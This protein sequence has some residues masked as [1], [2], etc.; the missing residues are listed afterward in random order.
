MGV[1]R[2][3]HSDKPYGNGRTRGRG[4]T[5]VELMVVLAITSLTAAFVLPSLTAFVRHAQFRRNEEQ[6]KSIYLDAEASLTYLRTSGQ[7]ESFR[8]ELV[9]DGA[10]RKQI[11]AETRARE[12]RTVYVLCTGGENGDLE[13]LDRL[14]GADSY[15][16][17]LR[18]AGICVEIDAEAGRV[19][20]AFYSTTADGFTY[21]DEQAE[22]YLGFDARSPEDR[23]ARRLGYYSVEDPVNGAGLPP[24]ANPHLTSL[25]LVNDERLYLTWESDSRE[26]DRDAAFDIELY[27]GEDDSLLWK[28]SLSLNGYAGGCMELA[29]QNGENVPLGTYSFPF[30]YNGRFELVLDAMMDAASLDA[31]APGDGGAR[32]EAVR[33]GSTSVT[34]LPGMDRPLNVYARVTVRSASDRESRF[35]T[36][37][38]NRENTM[39][40]SAPSE[41]G[42]YLIRSFRHL[43]NIRYMEP[44]EAEKPQCFRLDSALDWEL[45]GVEL[46]H[47][48]G[49]R[50]L[51]MSGDLVFPT[52]AEL[53]E[54]QILEG[55]GNTIR[56]LRLGVD[57]VSKR[58][59]LGLIGEN[60]GT[61]RNLRLAGPRIL[62]GGGHILVSTTITCAGTVCGMSGASGALQNI[63]VDGAQIRVVLDGAHDGGE[64]M[65]VGGVAG[66]VGAAAPG[67]TNRE[68]CEAKGL[69]VTGGSVEAYVPNV[70]DAADERSGRRGIGG[71]IGCARTDFY[72]GE[73]GP[74]GFLRVED[75]VNEAN[76]TGNANTGGVVGSLY[77]RPAALAAPP[78][79][80]GQAMR[81]CTNRGEVRG[82]D[83]RAYANEF[84]RAIGAVAGFVYNAGLEDCNNIPRADAPSEG[85]A[86][87]LVGEYAGPPA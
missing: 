84:P 11:P 28:T 33:T 13:L 45:D 9:K 71:V 21:T 53:R 58:S 39:F 16:G 68:S 60:E 22:G 54:G 73:E 19:Y 2:L 31:L 57:S 38:S 50:L 35:H 82:E 76:V 26:E 70:P 47:W 80:P 12:A 46:Y 86:V 40:A 37:E 64:D 79:G 87:E 32:R 1:E 15:G 5:L 44:P 17:S 30:S 69:R 49:E 62:G 3:K 7:W 20:S 65:G 83:V 24:L 74:V 75:C 10:R 51:R 56:N 27:D 55:A 36:R 25:Q 43:S 61:I 29:L 67:R 8:A 4:F 18:E 66:I 81:L 59:F 14:L 72:I 85:V 77:S 63:A 48:D 41:E 52:V 6:A 23:K 42:D 78:D 34:R